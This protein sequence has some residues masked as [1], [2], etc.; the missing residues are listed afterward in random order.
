MDL[1][2]CLHHFKGGYVSFKATT[3]GVW[4][5]RQVYR[6]QII[7]NSSNVETGVPNERVCV[8]EIDNR[9]F[10]HSQPFFFRKL[11]NLLVLISDP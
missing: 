11:S 5:T 8:P 9:A 2:G 7:T 1:F 10:F 3:S 6:T 4:V